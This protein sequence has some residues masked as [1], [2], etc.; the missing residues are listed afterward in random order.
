MKNRKKSSLSKRLI[1]YLN[2]K[3]LSIICKRNFLN[4]R[5][6]KIKEFN[7]I[8]VNK[9]NLVWFIDINE[10]LQNEEKILCMESCFLT[11]V[12]CCPPIEK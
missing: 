6:T 12:F 5:P 1:W 2:S 4:N 9:R 7:E 8:I 11:F 10:P 3:I